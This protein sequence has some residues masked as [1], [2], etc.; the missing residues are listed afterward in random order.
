MDKQTKAIIILIGVVLAV[1]L[2]LVDRAQGHTL[3]ELEE[4]Y[5]MWVAEADKAL[6]PDLIAQ[7][8]DM[9]ERHPYYF[10]ESYEDASD[11]SFGVTRPTYEGM[12]SNVLQWL[13]L[14]AGHFDPEDVDTAMCIMRYESGGNPD[15]KNPNSTAA[16]LFQFLRSTWDNMVPSS[17]TGGSYASGQVYQ[18]EANVR[19]AA[20]LQNAAGWTQWSPYKRG[21]CRGL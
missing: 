3:D 15:A 19:S 16:G 12:G 21:L 17:V 9:A 8:A 18:P 7:L 6:S 4:F 2:V 13:P 20:W 5:A 1:T 11:G 10:D 14:V